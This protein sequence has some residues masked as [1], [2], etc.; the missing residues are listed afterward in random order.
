M[1]TKDKIIHNKKLLD[2]CRKENIKW[3]AL[4]GSYNCGEQKEDSDIDFIVNIKGKK[5]L[6]KLIRI[7]N[8]ISDIYGKNIDLL[9]EDSLSPYLK[10]SILKEM[11]IRGNTM[12]YHG[13]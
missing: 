11:N 2:I 8:E 7:K 3:I 10:D 12:I 9:T 4:F 13:K 5:S 1:L 6:F